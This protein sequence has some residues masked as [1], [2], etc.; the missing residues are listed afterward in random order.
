MREW[1]FQSN[2]TSKAK[3]ELWD[4]RRSTFGAEHINGLSKWYQWSQY[5]VTLLHIEIN[6][7]MFVSHILCKNQKESCYILYIDHVSDT[8]SWE[9]QIF[10]V[11]CLY[12]SGERY[13][14]LRESDFVVSY[15]YR[16][17]EWYWLLRDS[18]FVVSY[19]YRSGERYWLLR[20]SYFVVS[21]VYRSGERYWLL[22][23]SD[24]V[25]S[26]VYRSGEWYWLLRDSDFVVS[27]VFRSGEW[28]WLLRDD[29]SYISCFVCKIL[30][31]IRWSNFCFYD[32]INF[33]SDFEFFFDE[34]GNSIMY[35]T[36]RES[37]KSS[38]K[39]YMYLSFLLVPYGSNWGS[40]MESYWVCLA[41]HPSVL[42]SVL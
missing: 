32:Y 37:T 33:T 17:G 23:D 6:S 40:I 18:D 16:S 28:Y 7:D 21:Y 8:D 24:F 14:L 9:T 29:Q 41:F 2:I 1:V 19:L 36:G 11:C 34:I 42:L 13:W 30:I 22:R 15:L 25:V 26:Y 31:R 5:N 4:T 27:Y 38:I 35:E 3:T 12:R 10:V 39:R 20:D